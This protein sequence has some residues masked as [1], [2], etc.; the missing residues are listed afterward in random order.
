[1]SN[2]V[3]SIAGAAEKETRLVV[4]GGQAAFAFCSKLREM[5]DPGHAVLGGEEKHAPNQ[6]PPLSKAYLLGETTVERLQFRP[7]QSYAEN[8]I[9]FRLCSRTVEISC[10]QR[11]VTL[12]DGSLLPC[13]HPVPATGARADSTADLRSLL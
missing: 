6:R 10:P 1:M 2:A 4:G 11:R 3:K 8:G 13:D 5:D 7:Q 9:E 12:E